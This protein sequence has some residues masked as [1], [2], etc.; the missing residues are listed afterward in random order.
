MVRCL[1]QQNAFGP[2]SHLKA[3]PSS[4][5]L[6]VIPGADGEGT[7]Y[8]DQGDSEAYKDGEFA[9]TLFTQTQSS[10]G[11]T[12]TIYPRQGSYIGMPQERA[13]QVVFFSIE[14][15]TDVN[16]DGEAASNWTYDEAS[17]RLTVN[18]STRPCSE[19]IVINFKD[20][21]TGIKEI[22]NEKLKMN[23]EAFDLSGRQMINGKWSGIYIQNGKKIIIPYK[24]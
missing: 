22:K 23:N 24:P 19:T 9:T 18:V 4:L 3:E 13:W 20:K 15:P 10:E 8:E 2:L 1:P 6:W 17:Q 16:V 14:E 11:V 7:L 5:V 12:L 21:E